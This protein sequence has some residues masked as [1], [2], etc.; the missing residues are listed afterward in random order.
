MYF[1]GLLCRGI[2]GLLYRGIGGLLCRGIGG[3]LCRGI[4]GLLCADSPI[5]K[6]LLAFRWFF[7]FYQNLYN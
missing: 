5:G 6:P 2:G 7:L 1:S 4:S 3:L